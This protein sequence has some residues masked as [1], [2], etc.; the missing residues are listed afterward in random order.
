MKNTIPRFLMSCY[1]TLNDI[2]FFL[3]KIGSRDFE[4]SSNF[5]P[6]LF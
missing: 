2:I 4:A 6:N 3:Q 1:Y 5:Q